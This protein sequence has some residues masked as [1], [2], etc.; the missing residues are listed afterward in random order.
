[1]RGRE[2]AGQALFAGPPPP[3][4]CQRR[5]RRSRC[6]PQRSS[7][8]S[9]TRESRAWISMAVDANA[10]ARGWSATEAPPSIRR[11]YFC[12]EYLLVQVS[13]HGNRSGTYVGLCFDARCRRLRA[14]RRPFYVRRLI[15]PRCPWIVICE[16]SSSRRITRPG[17]RR[18]L[19]LGLQMLWNCDGR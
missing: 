6:L 11:G 4:P 12:E 17:R 5:F 19:L 8:T 7:R 14:R 16:R 2:H 10:I 15:A 9:G 18:E 3:R 1:M 13:K